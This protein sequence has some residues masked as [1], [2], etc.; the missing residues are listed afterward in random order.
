MDIINQSNTQVVE[1]APAHAVVTGK[2]LTERKLSIVASASFE[3]TTYLAGKNGKVGKVAREGLAQHARAFI[4]A[5]A[6]QGNYRPLAE[7]LAGLM[8]ESISISNRSSYEGLLDRFSDKLLDLNLTKS[9]GWTTDKKTG[10]QKSSSKRAT[11]MECIS[12]VKEVQE[13]AETM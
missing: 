6:R 5:K 2:T 13:L 9:G 3:A 7:A 12:L 10:L 8:G 11:L 1:F 4:A